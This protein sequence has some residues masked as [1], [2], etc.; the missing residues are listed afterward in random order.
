MKNLVA[1]FTS[2]AFTLSTLQAADKLKVYI[3]A[4]DESMLRQGSIDTVPD[5]PRFKVLPTDKAEATPGTLLNVLKQKTDYAFLRA[6]DGKWSSRDDVAIYDAHSISNNTRDPARLLALPSD[7][8]DPRGYGVGAER[9][10][11]H[12]IGEA[13]QE[14]VLLI[15]FATKHE[16]WF[17]RGSRSLGYDYLPPSGGGGLD[18]DG[19]W[20][21][22][23]FNHGVWDLAAFD[24]ATNQ[25]A[26]TGNIKPRTSIED[27]EKN[28]R[29]IVERL[30]KTGATLIFANTHPILPDTPPGYFGGETVN[31]YNAVAAKVM[32][33]NGVILNDLNAE[34]RRLGHPKKADVHDVGNLAPKVT[35]V[36]M[37]A[38]KNRKNPSR[39]VPRV[40]FIGDSI[41]GT[42]WAK[43]KENLDGKAFVAKNPGNG[44]HS[45]TGTRMVD[46]WVDLKQYM[47]NGQEYL[48][49]VDSVKTA[50]ADIDRYAPDFAGHKPELAGFFWFQGIADSQSP[51]FAASYE[52]NLTAFIGDVRKALNAPELPFVVAAIGQHGEKMQPGQRT[53]HT[54]Q[55][56]VAKTT[57]RVAS[58]DTAPFYFPK[59]KSP[60]GREWDFHN[61]A[62]PFLLIGKAAGKAMLELQQK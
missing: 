40:L 7:P 59:E 37:E 32:K 16:T 50:L 34:C 15:R 2:I 17:S 57:A 26:L 41:T 55:M 31:K 51:A 39:P 38:L 61:H 53:V 5:G 25:R 6:S 52:Q 43:V 3:L 62:E 46:Q 12:V 21:V 42:Y 9:T 11:G 10:F 29:S 47:L 24:S 27:Y 22:I 28:L 56:N 49:L 60:G 1:F 33:E 45:G 36:V 23:H 8:K 19:N 48:E 20:D 44:E 35:E 18:L 30:K 54:A 14:P 13:T 58:I 4:G